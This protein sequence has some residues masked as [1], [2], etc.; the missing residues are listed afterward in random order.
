[1]DYKP[2]QEE[3][4]PPTSSASDS[5][6]RPVAPYPESGDLKILRQLIKHRAPVMVDLDEPM[7]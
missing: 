1:M 2:D 5:P 7:E 6:T 4:T 3:T